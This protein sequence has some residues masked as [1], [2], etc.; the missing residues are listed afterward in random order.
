MLH[1]LGIVTSRQCLLE[2][3]PDHHKGEYVCGP[4]PETKQSILSQMAWR[5]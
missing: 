1:S 2:D 4:Y 5:I 3:R